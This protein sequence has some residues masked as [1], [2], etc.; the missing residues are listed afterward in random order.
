[1]RTIKIYQPLAARPSRVFQALTEARELSAWQA[2]KVEGQVRQGSNLTFGWPMLGI[3]LTLDVVRVDAGRSVAFSHGSARLEFEMVRGGV[4]LR[5]TAPFDDDT[6][7]GTASSWRIALA[8]LKT[9][10]SRH[11]GRQRRVY[12]AVQRA[13]GRVELCHAYFTEPGLVGSWLGSTATAL[14]EVD[15]NVTLT[16]ASGRRVS[17]PML[18]HT[19]GRDLA[20][21]WREADDSVLVFR[22]LPVDSDPGSRYLLLG[23]SRWS[24]LPEVDSVQNEL[25]RAVSQLAR[26]LDRAGVA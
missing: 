14:G 20:I 8:T 15:S 21:R 17:G 13:R 11:A 24:E 5:H 7:A 9:Y 26:R 2:D 3:S 23:W 16:L 25:R 12:W 4:E 10:L 18:A 22:T 6:L 1:M 19:P